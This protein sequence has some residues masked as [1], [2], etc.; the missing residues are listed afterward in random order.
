MKS[1]L[2]KFLPQ[3]HRIKLRQS[4]IALLTASLNKAVKEQNLQ[5]I[6]SKISG[7]VPDISSQYGC[8]VVEGDY[9]LTKVRSQHAFQMSL[10]EK[11][12]QMLKFEGNESIVDIGDSAGTHVQY[13]K[14]LFGENYHTLSVDL[15]KEAIEKIRGKGL[16]AVHARAEELD[17]YDIK[18]DLFL[19]FEMLEHLLSPI[20]FLHSLAEKS[21]CKGAVVSVPYL[22]QG[23]V[24]L[25]HIRRNDHMAVYGENTHIFELSPSD[26]RLIFQH[27]GW[28][29]EYDQVYLQYPKRSWLKVSKFL[30]KRYDYE[31]FYGAILVRDTK[32]S[33]CYSDW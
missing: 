4:M 11:A 33:G 12:I 27:A 29:I 9:L 7:I 10:V 8:F 26:W 30:W 24:A 32:W 20:D 19:S 14:G 25:H 15:N 6:R 2:K 28:R 21:V 16:E 18:A 1:I 3:D 31:G 22:T 17:Q 23:R 5:I 13:L